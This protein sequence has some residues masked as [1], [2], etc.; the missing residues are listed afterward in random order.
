MSSKTIVLGIDGEREIHMKRR[1]KATALSRLSERAPGLTSELTDIILNPARRAQ[2]E[3]H[4]DLV[5][6]R[7]DIGMETLVKSFELARVKVSELDALHDFCVEVT[8]TTEGF[9][10]WEGDPVVWKNA[11]DAVKKDLYDCDV[12]GAVKVNM[13]LF[14]YL[15][16]NG[17]DPDKIG[18]DAEALSEEEGGANG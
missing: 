10:D 2:V 16:K 15:I 7:A 3:D 8:A 13:Y 17:I 18:Q 5:Q 6:S 11:S 12:P 4:I 9:R 14:A 1:F